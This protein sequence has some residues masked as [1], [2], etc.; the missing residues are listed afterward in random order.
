LSEKYQ[1]L[2][3][4]KTTYKKKRNEYM[5]SLET[6]QNQNARTGYNGNAKRKAILNPHKQPKKENTSVSAKEND[7][8]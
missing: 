8:P 2:D 6:R 7:R 5:L 3:L 1:I 4:A